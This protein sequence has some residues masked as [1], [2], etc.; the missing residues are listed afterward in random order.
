LDRRSFLGK[1]CG[2]ALG[3]LGVLAAVVGGGFLYPVSRRKPPAQFVCLESML[4]EGKPHEIKD[5]AGRNVLLMRK[6][7]GTVMAVGTVCS[8]LGCAVFY[9]PNLNQFECPCHQGFFD[10]DGNPVSGPPQRPLDRFPVEIRE[11]KVFVQFP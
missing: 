5:P 11:K 10:G 3:L 2:G 1:L 9:R 8:H 6:S 4:L 7:G